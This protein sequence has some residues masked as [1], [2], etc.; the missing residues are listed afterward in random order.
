ML[1]SGASVHTVNDLKMLT[2]VYELDEPNLIIGIGDNEEYESTIA[3]TCT[4]NTENDSTYSF[5]CF[6]ADK[7][8]RNYFSL[9]IYSS[10]SNE[11]MQACNG[12]LQ[13]FLNDELLLSATIDDE[14]DTYTANLPVLMNN[15]NNINYNNNN[16]STCEES[17]ES[18]NDD[19]DD[20]N[21]NKCFI[22][23]IWHRRLCHI[24]VRKLKK[25][26]KIFPDLNINFNDSNMCEECL[27]NKSQR[28]AFKA[29]F[30]RAKDILV[31]IDLSGRLP[32]SICGHRYYIA[33]LDEFSNY[34]CVYFLK[35]KNEV[36]SKIKSYVV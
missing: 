10:K 7:L 33:I 21:F 1:D 18:N 15:N 5:N 3:G 36:I 28:P 23:N 27:I 2:N 16:E 25:M 12:Q 35:H 31:H 4:I 9:S 19:D 26:S 30:N 20:E 22:N 34:C 29:N 11:M 13:L 6:Y 17:S 24:P 8:P 32:T 14:Y